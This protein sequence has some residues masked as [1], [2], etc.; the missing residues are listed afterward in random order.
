MRHFFTVFSA[1]LNDV[2]VFNCLVPHNYWTFSDGAEI[3]E[4]KLEVRINTRLIRL[5]V[6]FVYMD[7]CIRY[8]E[9]GDF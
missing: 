9:N 1:C 5:A 3:L 8:P 7:I 4:F 2:I 6:T